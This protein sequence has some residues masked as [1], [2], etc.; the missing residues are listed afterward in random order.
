MKN[1][2]E[3]LYYL[4]NVRINPV[5][6]EGIDAS[7]RFLD[8]WINET[9]SETE[10]IR[11][12]LLKKSV[13]IENEQ[14]LVLL[15]YQCE[16]ALIRLLDKV[17]SYMD[18]ASPLNGM[19]D[20]I[21]K[22]LEK[23]L[24]FIECH[25][26]KYF[27][28]EEKVPDHLLHAT[29]ALIKKELRQLE[30][31]VFAGTDPRLKKIV[32]NHLQKFT[33]H[34]SQEFICYKKV[35]Y[36]K[37][38]VTELKDISSGFTCSSRQLMD[39]LI[40][41]NFNTADLFSYYVSNIESTTAVC[42]MPAQKRDALLSGLKTLNQLQEK[43]GIAFKPKM[44]SLKEQICSWISEEINYLDQQQACLHASYVQSMPTQDVDDEEKLHTSLSV[45]QLAIL[46]RAA[47]D[48]GVLTNKN[49]SALLKTFAKVFRTP[50]AETISAESLRSKYY[51]TESNALESVKDILMK[52]F[53][54]AQSY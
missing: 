36:I 54:K 31:T 48:T 49:Q 10:S 47:R 33:Q 42:N 35:A 28:K 43:P 1:S 13:D 11:T 38:L 4:I 7:C 40:Y 50:Q 52:M 21:L 6:T 22:R 37:E 26:P 2:L 41:M 17:F 46:I 8:I 5:N 29:Q 16:S 14:S 9:I 24:H 30:K 34:N 15:I 19:Y 27:N 32:C 51:T 23:L 45:Q 18:P 3:K 53:N 44:R 12:Y 20:T 25:Y 39:L